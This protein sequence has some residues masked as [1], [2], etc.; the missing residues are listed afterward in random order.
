MP[1]KFTGRLLFEN[2]RTEVFGKFV[3]PFAVACN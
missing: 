1:V 3:P 2:E